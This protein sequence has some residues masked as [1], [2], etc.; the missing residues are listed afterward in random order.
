MK[1]YQEV[2]GPRGAALQIPIPDASRSG[3]VYLLHGLKTNYYKIGHS[4]HLDRRVAQISPILPFPVRVVA[5]I[6]SD[7]RYAAELYMH[8]YFASIR[9]EGEWFECGDGSIIHDFNHFGSRLDAYDLAIAKELEKEG[10]H[11]VV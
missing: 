4:G 3:F 7:D 5:V 2:I 11:E 10:P 9:L 6:E 8:E 1:A